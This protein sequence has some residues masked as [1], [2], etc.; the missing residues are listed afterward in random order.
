MDK[1]TCIDG[2][3]ETAQWCGKLLS[4]DLSLTH[5]C[6]K[7]GFDDISMF[8]CCQERGEVERET[9]DSLGLTGQ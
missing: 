5:A 2:Y 9:R 4:Q 3:E 6:I 7:A 1:H 8:Q